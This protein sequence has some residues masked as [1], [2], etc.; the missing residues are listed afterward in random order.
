[1]WS[2]LGWEEAADAVSHPWRGRVG[3]GDKGLGLGVG[4]KHEA[5]G[6]AGDEEPWRE[7]KQ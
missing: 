4:H 1:M 6:T 5:K 2:L 7:G 3:R